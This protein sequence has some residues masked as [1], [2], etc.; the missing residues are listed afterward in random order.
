[1][2]YVRAPLTSLVWSGDCFWIVS[3][4][5]NRRAQIDIPHCDTF[6]LIRAVA[7]AA[8]LTAVIDDWLTRLQQ[9][10]LP[11]LKYDDVNALVETG[12]LVPRDPRRSWL[13]EQEASAEDLFDVLTLVAA[14][15]STEFADYAEDNTL[16]R[17]AEQMLEYTHESVPPPLFLLH[18]TNEAVSLAPGQ[19]SPGNLEETIS[20]LLLAGF[21]YF[22]KRR[23]HNHQVLKKLVPSLGG[24]HGLEAYLDVRGYEPIRSGLY[25]Y[26]VAEHALHL[27]APQEAESATISKRLTL[28]VACV[29][30]RY[31]WRYRNSWA[32]RCI[33]FDVGHVIE[34]LRWVCDAANWN[35]T[36]EG[37]LGCASH[38]SSVWQGLRHEPLLAL[39]L[40]PGRRDAT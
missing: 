9:A 33:W 5:P 28:I 6:E 22:G 7:A 38:S 29:F 31:Q 36:V 17:D 25:H 10:G 37:K 27:L 21:G 2:E 23:F 16:T 32:Y 40:T 18:H 11:Q 8:N 24:R 15:R 20:F 12:I 1:M 39:T 13:A 19:L 34:T 14:G 30:D 3:P 35:L 4:E 26:S